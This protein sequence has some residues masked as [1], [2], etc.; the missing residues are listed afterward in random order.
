MAEDAGLL[1]VENQ[2][3]TLKIKKMELEE[4]SEKVLGMKATKAQGLLMK[5]Q[6][7]LAEFLY[8]IF[9]IISAVDNKNKDIKKFKYPGL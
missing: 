8:R 2:M 3:T 7:G 4:H 5:F 9:Q 6:L 1:E